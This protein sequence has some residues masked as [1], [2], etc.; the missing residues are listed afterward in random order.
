MNAT[1]PCA[2]LSAVRTNFRRVETIFLFAY[3]ISMRLFASARVMLRFFFF[4]LV[5]FAFMQD[6]VFAASF[7]EY[8]NSILEEIYRK[9]ADARKCA[10]FEEA[11]KFLKDFHDSILKEGVQSRISDEARLTFDNLM[12]LERWQCFW[13]INPSM[14]GIKEMIWAQYE[15][16][17]SWNESHPFDEQ[18]PYLKISSFDLINSTMQYLKQ[19]QLIKLGLQEKKVCDD[20]VEKFPKM[21]I[22]LL[23]TGHW[24]YNAPPIGGGSRSKARKLYVRAVENASNDYERYFANIYLS[25]STLAQEG[26]GM[27][28]ETYR[29]SIAAAEAAIPRTFYIEFIKKLNEAG[30]NLYEYALNPER[31]KERVFG[32]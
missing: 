28:N 24:Y 15:K 9:R 14:P 1:P 21:S 5:F 3:Y 10:S 8:E 23:F 31:I 4:A 16:I 26:V 13:E 20:L 12:I 7:T 11:Q 6:K 29:K 32:K 27:D 30:V 17:L 25:Q 22:A 2:G 18:N 19:S